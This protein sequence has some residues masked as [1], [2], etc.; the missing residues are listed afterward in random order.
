MKKTISLFLLLLQ[1]VALSYALN[2]PM[3][4]NANAASVS[5]NWPASTGATGYQVFWSLTRGGPYTVGSVDEGNVTSATVSGL[6]LGASYYFVVEAYDGGGSST[7]SP[8]AEFEAT[9]IDAPTDTA[10]SATSITSST[11]TLNGTVTDIGGASNTAAGFNYGL[12]TAYG[13]NVVASG[14]PFSSTFSAGITGLTPN[15]TYHFR[16]Y[17]TNSEQTGVSADAT[18]T[19]SPSASTEAFVQSK[20]VNGS[21]STSVAATLTSAETAGNLNVVELAWGAATGSVSSVTD[22]L[23]NTYSLALLTQVNGNSV[24][25]YVASGIASGSDT[26]TA[27][28]S[29]SLVHDIAVIEYSGVTAVDT[30]VGAGATSNSPNSGNI[31]T[32]NANDILVSA[33]FLRGGSFNGTLNSGF[34]LRVGASGS[35]QA[36]GD[37]IVSATGTYNATAGMGASSSWIAQIIALKP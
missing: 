28:F 32:A 3:M 25:T 18:F 22:S 12:T 34:T 17:S 16:A 19:T 26:V 35:V 10:Q 11:A 36:S 37:D 29:T 33:L 5:L 14:G 1:T 31:T 9:G 24:A 27:T 23:G 6:T 7:N 30:S 8:E 15:T 2:A 20:Q 13:S 4:L 21:S